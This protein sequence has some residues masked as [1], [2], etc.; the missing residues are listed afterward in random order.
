M[1]GMVDFN[2]EKLRDCLGNELGLNLDALDDET[3]LFS[4]GTVDSFALV[5][6]LT[7][8]EESAEIRVRPLDVTLENFDSVARILA[9]VA[10]RSGGDGG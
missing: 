10:R 1:R 9:Y 3:L 7:W 4:S 2:R 6:L 5:R 8:I